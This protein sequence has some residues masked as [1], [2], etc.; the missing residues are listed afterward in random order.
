MID[1]LRTLARA[2]TPIALD[3]YDREDPLSLLASLARI[4]PNPTRRKKITLEWWS[5]F[6][7]LRLWVGDRKTQRLFSDSLEIDIRLYEITFDMDRLDVETEEALVKAQ[8]LAEEIA[9]AFIRGKVMLAYGPLRRNEL[10]FDGQD[11]FDTQHQHA[12]GKPYSNLLTVG[13]DP[14]K[15]RANN[16]E[17]TPIELREELKVVMSRL[18]ENSLVR[19]TLVSTAEA[20]NNLVVIA[21]SFDVWSAFK[22]LLTEE[23][24]DQMPNRFRG[25]FNLI[26]DVEFDGDLA[27]VYDVIRAD[28]GGP[29]PV[30]FVPTQEPSGLQF[31]ETQEFGARYIPFGMHAQYGVATGFP[32]TAIR[33]VAP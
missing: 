27:N 26:R 14:L 16:A 5:A 32:Q 4:R 24:L 7:Q 22:D 10:A 20:E 31:D 9:R 13:L 3:I 19:N 8:D 1:Q 21:R 11:F 18:L 28:P 29:R 2:V 15:P 25:K 17:P 6:P 30:I 23:Q 33:V 12:T